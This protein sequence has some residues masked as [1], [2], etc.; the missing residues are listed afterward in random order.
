M[1]V[2]FVELSVP[3]VVLGY[4]GQL[5]PTKLGF[6]SLLLFGVFH[7]ALLRREP[8][9][10]FLGECLEAAG[11]LA[12]LPGDGLRET[13]RLRS[14][15]FVGLVW[16][17][18]IIGYAFL[19]AVR[20]PVSTWD[21]FIYHQPIIGFAIQNHGFAPVSLP[22]TVAVQAINGYPRF[23]EAMSIWLSIFTDKTL[24]ELPNILGAVAMMLAVFALARRYGDRMLAIGWAAAI[25]LLPQA[26]VQL[27]LVCIDVLVGSFAITALYF[28]TRPH[29]RIR[30]AWIAIAS[31]MLLMGSKASAY[32]MVP[33]LAFVM[34]ARLIPRHARAR[35]LAVACVVLGAP[36]VIGATAALTLRQN[37]VAFHN[38][39]WPITYDNQTLGIHWHGLA[40]VQEAVDDAPLRDVLRIIYSIPTGIKGSNGYGSAFTW[41][42]LPFGCVSIIAWVVSRLARRS[43]NALTTN[44][45]WTLLLLAVGLASSPTLNPRNG[46]YNFHLVAGFMVAISWLFA[47]PLWLRMRE[48]VLGASVALSLIPFAWLDGSAWSFGMTDDPLTMLSSPFGSRAYFP[49]PSFDP[50]AKQRFLEL[51]RGDRVAFDKDVG[52]IGALWNFDYSNEV[53]F[54]P[55]EAPD[56][57]LRAVEAYNPKWVAVG[58]SGRFDAL[59]KSGRWVSVGRLT[60]AQDTEVLTRK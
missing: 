47:R 39:L 45:G 49:K 23:C 1:T 30:D 9:R 33:P 34:C 17:G 55:E 11:V 50:L 43:R 20:Y 6:F 7:F 37:W 14:P 59:K 41:V 58:Q 26:W 48:G 15:A 4:A 2:L 40:T 44:L 52:F 35:P 10:Q 8:W 53:R 57:Y 21:G 27:P 19:L 28:S 31:M 51:G 32:V 36:V 12:R 54:F 42:I 29:L 3:V 46:R 24:E 5:T 22:M 16:S 60:P 13:A 56:A 18:G 25:V 38:P